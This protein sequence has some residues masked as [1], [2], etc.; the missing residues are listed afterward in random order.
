MRKTV[1]PAVL[2]TA[3]CL[4]AVA[5]FTGP[6]AETKPSTV[7]QARESLPGAYV[8]LT[9]NLVAH[10][11]AEVYTFRDASGEMRVE[12]DHEIWRNRG[13][14]PDTKVQLNGEVDL[15]VSGRYLSVDSLQVVP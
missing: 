2:V 12:I 5:Q 3:F 1:L 9:G 8:T 13:V 7:A 4:P 11:H 15:G 14:N 6:S 10:V